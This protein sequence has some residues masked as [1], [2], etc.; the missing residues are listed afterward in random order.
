MP[1]NPLTVYILTNHPRHTVLYI[2]VTNDLLRRLRE[3]IHGLTRGFAWKMNCKKLL[4]CERFI[5]P[6]SAIECE[7]RLKGWIR[8]KKEALI[9]ES[10][11]EWRDLGREMF[12]DLL[13][14]FTPE[15]AGRGA[16][17]E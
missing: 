11:P 4:W 6:L 8:A 2:G 5:D 12:G 17:R 16:K 7:K 13:D 10:N 1:P 9:N 3:H 15:R 14:D